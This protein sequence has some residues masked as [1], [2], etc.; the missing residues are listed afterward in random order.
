MQKLV[1]LL[2]INCSSTGFGASLRPS[3]GGQTA[4]HCLCTQCTQLAT[5]LSSITTA[6]TGQKTIGSETQ[7]EP[8]DDGRKDVRNLLRNNWL[9]IKSLIVA[10]SSSRLYLLIKDSRSFEHKEMKKFSSPTH[11]LF[12]QFCIVF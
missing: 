5:R 3:S 1:I 9:P 4:F 12:T 10:S 11:A 2:V 7:S 8:P 6:T